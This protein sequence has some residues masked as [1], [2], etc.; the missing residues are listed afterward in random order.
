MRLFQAALVASVIFSSQSSFG[1]ALADGSQRL[2]MRTF[3][4]VTGRLSEDHEAHFELF[5]FVN[6]GL[7]ETRNAPIPAQH[8]LII[9]RKRP[10]TR[11]RLF[12]RQPNGMLMLGRDSTGQLTGLTKDAEVVEPTDHSKYSNHR[13]LFPVSTGWSNEG[14]LIHTYSGIFGFSNDWTR[15]G[16]RE[17]FIE[18][19]AY[20]SYINFIYSS[21]DQAWLAFHATFKH[22]YDK[23][24]KERASQG[25]VRQT[26][27]NAQKIQQLLIA[28]TG[29][30]PLMNNLSDYAAGTNHGSYGYTDDRQFGQLV[31]NFGRN[32]YTL[33]PGGEAP[34]GL[35]IF[36]NDYSSY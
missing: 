33:V 1:R 20:S 29:P 21:G 15:A 25:C 34:K 24:G 6:T 8:L 27:P 18:G 30:V 35:A 9:K 14:N 32:T 4:Y 23:L 7:K 12:V 3:E 13:E 10:G 26:I 36:F 31:K 16:T 22:N 11:T 5:F 28:H 17:T 19:M 2:P